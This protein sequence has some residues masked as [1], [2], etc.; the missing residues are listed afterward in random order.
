MLHKFGIIMCEEVIAGSKRMNSITTI[1]V[2]KAEYLHGIFTERYHTALKDALGRVTPPNDNCFYCNNFLSVWSF[3]SRNSCNI[4]DYFGICEAHVA[5][6]FFGN[7][8]IT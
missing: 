2:S 3:L 7:F 4:I 5:G 1:D 8:V 6:P